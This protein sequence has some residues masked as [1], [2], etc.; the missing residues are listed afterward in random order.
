MIKKREGKNRILHLG[1][2]GPEGAATKYGRSGGVM[3]PTLGHRFGLG[4]FQHHI[5]SIVQIPT[6]SAKG[7]QEMMRKLALG[8]A[9]GWVWRENSSERVVDKWPPGTHSPTTASTS[10]HCDAGS[11]YGL[12]RGGSFV[13]R[14]T[15]C[16]S[17]EKYGARR[18]A[19]EQQKES[20]ICTTCKKRSTP[21]DRIELSISRL[22]IS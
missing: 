1:R 3:D 9:R 22:R 21:P 17:G 10:R 8:R 20:V 2:G 18:C 13:R 6:A 12:I 16:V 7:E 19:V 15:G 4:E 11:V 14:P 5:R